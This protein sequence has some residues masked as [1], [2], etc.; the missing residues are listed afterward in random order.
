MKKINLSLMVLLVALVIMSCSQSENQF[1]ASGSFETV[2]TIISAEAQGV[3]KVFALEEGQT[4]KANT[5]I[6]YIDSVQLS[7]KKNQMEA[8]ISAILSKKPNVSLQ[9]AALQ[10]QLKTAEREKERVSNLVK[11]D[12]AT[13]KQLDDVNAQV[14]LIKRQLSAQKSNLDITIES[15]KSETAPLEIQI[16]QIKDL[17]QK[18]KIIN[19]ISGTVLTKYA[20]TN[21]MAAPGKPLYK[22]ADISTLILR[23]Y[24]SGNQLPQVQLNQKV[25]V[26]TDNGAGGFNETQGVITWISSKAEFTPKTIQ[27]KEERANKVYA[28]KVSVKNDGNLKIGM[29]G[30]VK[31]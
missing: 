9:L 1:D 25:T 27:T 8:Q 7:L 5:E 3:I 17:I 14:Q 30:E 15:L 16:E 29:Y 10:E 21:E 19:P 13:A 6:G 4:L 23:I 18:S 2:E 31:F 28:V 26:K 22:I 11:A 12:A 20:E 24:I